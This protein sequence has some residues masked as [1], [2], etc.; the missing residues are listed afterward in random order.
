MKYRAVNTKT[1][2]ELLKT[3]CSPIGCRYSGTEPGY[4]VGPDINGDL[5][6]LATC[7]S[8]ADARKLAASWNDED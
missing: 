6:H 4:V 7:H 3:Q 5:S 1:L 2:V 8:M